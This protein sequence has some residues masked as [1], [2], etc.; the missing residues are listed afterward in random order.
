MNTHGESSRETS[1]DEYFIR[2]NLIIIEI[3]NIYIADN[4]I[5]DPLERCK[6]QQSPTLYAVANIT[7]LVVGYR[8]LYPSSFATQSFVYRAS[9]NIIIVEILATRIHL[10]IV[11]KTHTLMVN[12]R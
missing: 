4:H 11:H 5:R 12:Y 1:A 2:Y 9:R 7:G 8:P 10:Q 3:V 6:R